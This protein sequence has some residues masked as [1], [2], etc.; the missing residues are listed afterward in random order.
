MCFEVRLVSEGKNCIVASSVA[1]TKLSHIT[2]L[3]AGKLAVE[4]AVE[5]APTESV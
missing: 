3:G 4:L 2:F 1:I 5:L